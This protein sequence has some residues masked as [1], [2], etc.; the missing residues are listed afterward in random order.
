MIAKRLVSQAAKSRPYNAKYNAEVI[1]RG[2]ILPP[3]HFAIINEEN[4]KC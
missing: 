4:K 1:C 3:I 2:G